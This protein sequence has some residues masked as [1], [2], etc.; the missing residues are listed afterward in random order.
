MIPKIVHQTYKT[1]AAIPAHWQESYLSWKGLEAH[2]WQ[3]MFWDDAKMRDLIADNY[4]WFLNQYDSYPKVIQRVDAWRIFALYHYGGLYTDLDIVCKPDKF[5]PYFEVIQNETVVL[6]KT[7]T[8]NGVEGQDLSNCFMLSEPHNEFW[9]HVWKTLR[10]PYKLLPYK[11]TLSYISPYYG[12]LFTSGPGIIADSYY[13]YD[14]K[15]S[16]YVLP[17]PLIQPLDDSKPKPHDT[18]ESLVRIIEG[19]SWHPKSVS[20]WRSFGFFDRYAK[21]ILGVLLGM[22]MIVIVVLSIKLHQANRE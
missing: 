21:A 8:G 4:S 20:F 18:R 22:C 14:K 2:G 3:Y 13:T 1:E 10:N 16:I 12:V 7:K 17:A 6:P 11:A 15:S 19:N 5:L 9:P